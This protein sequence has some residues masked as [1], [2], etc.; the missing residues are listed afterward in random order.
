MLTVISNILLDLVSC[1]YWV[2]LRSRKLSVTKFMARFGIG[3][4][5][6]KIGNPILYGQKG[7]GQTSQR[8]QC[9]FPWI[10][11]F[12]KIACIVLAAA[13]L[14]HIA[15]VQ[16]CHPLFIAVRL[17]RNCEPNI[18]WLSDRTLQSAMKTRRP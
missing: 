14:R 17:L 12:S 6:T 13:S 8:S 9:F 1:F 18:F 7:T 4:R 11:H 2:V 10:F 5:S 16:L 15:E 3:F